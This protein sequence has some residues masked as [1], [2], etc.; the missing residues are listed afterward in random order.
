MKL[1]SIV[2]KLLPYAVILITVSSIVPWAKIPIGNT[3]IW[4]TIYVLILR[5]LFL[6]KRFFNCTK[7]KEVWV[8]NLFLFCVVA[9]FVHGIV[10]SEN[11]W[12]WKQLMRNF[13]IFLLPITVYS[14][15]NPELLV[16]TLK[17]WLKY[18]L[19]LF[20]VFFLFVGTEAYG[21]YLLPI[22]FLMLFFPK[23]PRVWK[24]IGLGVILFLI[25]IAPD[26]RSNVIKFVVPLGFSL[27]L[28]LKGAVLKNILVLG[29]VV[30]LSLPFVLFALAAS[31][32]FNVFNM[33]E[34][35]GGISEDAV[36]INDE[37]R[38]QSLLNDT[39]T[40]LY[41]EEISSALKNDYW[42]FGRSM[43]RGYDTVSF[44]KFGNIMQEETNRNERPSS[45]VSILNIFNYFGIVGVLL[46]FFIFV[47]ASYYAI[48]K[49]NNKYIKL[50]G[51]YVSFRWAYAW[52]ED[53]NSFDL[54]YFLL[55]VIV[56]ICFS[57]AYRGMTN[58]EFEN[59]LNSILGTK[60]WVFK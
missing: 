54:N 11:Y 27:L 53:F 19:A 50:I 34:Y 31:G 15:S 20:P 57:V 4:Y 2:Y 43:A 59:W 36:I 44:A 60:R 33:S 58:R 8:I 13:M 10:I 51:L 21:K 49:S 47:A 5:L 29:R 6:G 40:F 7:K 23:V 30:F 41:I 37:G 22:S 39:R 25:I 12:D 16:K 24:L 46:Y 35:L 1:S 56:G 14:Y 26:S 3:Y 9:S 48:S 55:W 18:G 32:I 28:F 42:L 52:V 38:E 45:E 17:F